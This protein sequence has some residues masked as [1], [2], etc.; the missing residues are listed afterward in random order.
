MR[1]ELRTER[2]E[3]MVDI[4]ARVQEAVEAA[5]VHD[6]A[7]L[8]YCPHTTA[9]I[10]VTE[11]ADPDVAKD[12]LDALAR[13]APRDA[14]WRHAEGN[15]DAHVKS[16]LVGGSELVPIA[17]GRLVLGTWQGLFFCEFD[18]PRRRTFSVT[19]LPG[20]DS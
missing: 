12:V 13:I 6:G 10:A 9:A 14:G 2:R 15:S 3:Q 7:A 8:V 19:V 4:T 17:E 16:V 11:A 18:G 1:L 20:G 5:S